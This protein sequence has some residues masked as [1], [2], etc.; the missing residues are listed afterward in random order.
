LRIGS[1][2]SEHPDKKLGA[3]QI[4]DQSRKAA[5]LHTPL[6]LVGREGIRAQL[7]T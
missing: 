7:I 2:V 3:G 6:G 1:K 4:R 5:L